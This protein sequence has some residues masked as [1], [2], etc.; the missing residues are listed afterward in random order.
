MAEMELGAPMFRAVV[1]KKLVTHYTVEL[2]VRYHRKSFLDKKRPSFK[3]F[4]HRGAV[5]NKERLQIYLSAK[6]LKPGDEIY[7]DP[8][9]EEW[10][11]P[12]YYDKFRR[13]WN[14]RFA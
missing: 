6:K 2:Y 14:L 12:M 9:G 8:Y 1:V 7:V 5:E 4:V 13:K 11:D 10:C 3:V